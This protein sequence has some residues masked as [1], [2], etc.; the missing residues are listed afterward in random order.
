MHLMI[1]P[2]Y[3]PALTH[4]LLINLLNGLIHLLQT[5]PLLK[6]AHPL[7]QLPL[8]QLN[9]LPKRTNHLIQA[10]NLFVQ[11]AGLFAALFVLFGEF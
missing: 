3:T 1:N 4:Q 10:H 7:R 2:L 11:F 9:P 5:H 6:L 8:L